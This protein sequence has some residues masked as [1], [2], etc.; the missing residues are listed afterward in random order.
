MDV[1]VCIYMYIFWS[2]RN[3]LFVRFFIFGTSYF[4]R[5]TG[6]N[7]RAA[8][9]SS[10][11]FSLFQKIYRSFVGLTF[12]SLNRRFICYRRCNE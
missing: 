3:S 12:V 4:Q 10:L 6:K 2:V 11:Y 9:N 5:L 8:S 1:Y 7:I